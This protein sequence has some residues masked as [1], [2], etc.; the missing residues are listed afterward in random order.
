MDLDLLTEQHNTMLRFQRD[1]TDLLFNSSQSDAN[2]IVN[3][4]FLLGE[5]L[6]HIEYTNLI[7]MLYLLLVTWLLVHV[8]NKLE[9]VLKE[10][11][12]D[13]VEVYDGYVKVP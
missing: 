6:N 13:E 10:L 8:Y 5:H 3:N 1:T 11:E 9:A 4:Q 7:L 12:A 2:V